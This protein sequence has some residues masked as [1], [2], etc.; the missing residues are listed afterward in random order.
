MKYDENGSMHAFRRRRRPPPLVAFL[1]KHTAYDLLPVSVKVVVLDTLLPLRKAIAAL[2]LN[3]LTAAP[4]W[5]SPTMSFFGLLTVADILRLV[6]HYADSLAAL[7]ETEPASLADDIDAITVESLRSYAF[8]PAPTPASSAS[9]AASTSTPPVVG[10]NPLKIHPLRSVLEAS[11]TMA[12]CHLHHLP[13]VDVDSVNK[14][15]TVVSVLSGSKILRFLACNCP[16]IRNL[17]MPLPPTLGTSSPHLLTAT[18]STPL[19]DAIR[20]MANHDISALPIIDPHTNT[21]LDVFSETDVLLTV[22]DF[23]TVPMWTPLGEA[24]GRRPPESPLS[25][26]VYT[27]QRTDTVAS[28]FA[29]IQQGAK[30]TRFMV[31]DAEGRLEGVVTLGD[32]LGWVLAYVP[33]APDVQESFGAGS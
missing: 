33:E 24:L 6:L 31:V 3:G 16:S 4:L 18:P 5:H 19:L 32:L 1:H 26:A 13:L 25:S 15:E 2:L 27:C 23:P 20:L 12:Q 30:V 28:L 29:I 21:L 10:L 22:R 7:P 17:T 9:V 11:Q 8:A 14:Q